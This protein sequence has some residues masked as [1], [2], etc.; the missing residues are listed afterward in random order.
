VPAA[1]GRRA[2]EIASPPA[3]DAV[4]RDRL[5]RLF[6]EASRRGALGPGEVADTID[7]A[8]GFATVL[9]AA[10]NLLDLGSGAGVPGLVLAQLLPSARV[11]LVES[12]QGRADALRLAV[13]RS[14]LGDRVTVVAGRAERLGHEPE[15]RGALDAVVARG[16]GPP[17][18][19]AECAAPFLR[20]GGQLVVSEPPRDE[21]SRWPRDD[22]AAFGLRRDAVRGPYASFTQVS[23][24]PARFA[25][26]H[27]GGPLGRGST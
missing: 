13:A 5:V 19:T 24:C 10:G 16:F 1:P 22:L 6:N 17:L 14:G 15:W 21:G 8:A 2:A 3:L 27:P 9:R 4:A 25:R 26:Q 18:V 7:H 11:T 20:V 23:P 12:R